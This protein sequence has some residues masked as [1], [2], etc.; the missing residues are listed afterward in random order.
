MYDESK[1][2]I[3]NPFSFCSLEYAGAQGY[4]TVAF[5]VILLP[6]LP[7]NIKNMGDGEGKGLLDALLT[8]FVLFTS[9]LFFPIFTHTVP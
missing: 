6:F 1:T 2:I 5:P 9:F 3:L 7:K 8:L 4:G